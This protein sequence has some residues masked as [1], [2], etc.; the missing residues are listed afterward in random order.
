[1]ELRR[2][3]WRKGNSERLWRVSLHQ[4]AAAL[5]DTP[6]DLIKGKDIMACLQVIWHS[7]RKTA[8]RVR[9]RIGVI[10]DWAVA[11]GH[12]EFNPVP[13]IKHAM[14]QQSHQRRHFQALPHSEVKDAI[15]K[16][17]SSTSA[18][19]TKLAFEFLILT[20]A[21]SGEVRGAVWGE[22]DL[23]AAVWTVPAARMKANKVHRGAV[24][25]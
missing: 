16:V 24:V 21:R 4:H 11:N 9:D 10:M 13:A 3:K 20:A 12:R 23:D 22:I 5:M 15:A 7:K 19:A 25:A 14:P 17:R 6:I 1:M 8:S 2:P 18:T